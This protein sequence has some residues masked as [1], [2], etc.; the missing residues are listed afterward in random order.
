MVNVYEIRPGSY[1]TKAEVADAETE[2]GVTKE[3]VDAGLAEKQDVLTAGTNITIVENVISATG[4]GTEYTAG[5]GIAISG[6][7]VISNT[8]QPDVD[9]AYVDAQLALKANSASLATVATSGSYNDLSDKPTIPDVSGLAKDDLS[10]V[11]VSTSDAGKYLKVANDGS[12]SFDMPASGSDVEVW[13]YTGN[14]ANFTHGGETKDKVAFISYCVANTS[15]D[16]TIAVIANGTRAR[17]YYMGNVGGD[18]IIIMYVEA[19]ALAS[20]GMTITVDYIQAYNYTRHVLN[21]KQVQ[22]LLVS[23]TNI[24]TINS[25]SLLGSGDIA[26]EGVPDTTGASAGDVLTFDGTDVGWA[27]GG[28]S[29]PSN[30]VTT[31]TAQ[32]IT[33]AKTF[34]AIGGGVNNRYNIKLTSGIEG[35]S[36][37]GIYFDTTFTNYPVRLLSNYDRVGDGGL[38]IIPYIDSN[39]EYGSGW[40]AITA[41][42]KYNGLN[43]VWSTQG[44]VVPTSP[45]TIDDR[46]QYVD[47]IASTTNKALVHAKWVKDHMPESTITGDGTT[48]AFTVTHSLGKMPGIVQVTASDGTVVKD[49]E[50]T[51][52][53]STTNVV[54]TFTTAPA[55]QA[56]YTVAMLY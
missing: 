17:G 40:V 9:K 6:E 14:Y 2:G 49:S 50:I 23:G 32:T 42:K 47:N 27:A 56:T 7:N 52:V 55:D 43:M 22:E 26:I 44:F 24:K 37:S 19:S 34:T 12:I 11:E 48:T 51:I 54:V 28:G 15:A 53:K 8:A 5:S 18:S 36:Y 29:A 20:S 38:K 16:K 3:Y 4:G 21:N 30:M 10:N 41:A 1:A 31:D 33:G 46:N 35:S 13:T 25:T 45:T 39:V